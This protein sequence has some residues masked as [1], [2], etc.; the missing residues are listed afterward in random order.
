MTQ[1]RVE[2]FVIKTRHVS[3]CGILHFFSLVIIMHHH[4]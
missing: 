1:I 3:Y 4:Q 2:P